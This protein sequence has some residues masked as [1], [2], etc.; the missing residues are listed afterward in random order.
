M[1][2]PDHRCCKIDQPLRNQG[3]MSSPDK[4]R[5]A[6]QVQLEV[7]EPHGIGPMASGRLNCHCQ[8]QDGVGH[9][10]Y[11]NR[12]T[13][14]RAPSQNMATSPSAEAGSDP[15]TSPIIL[16]DELDHSLHSGSSFTHGFRGRSRLSEAFD[17]VGFPSHQA[18]LPSMSRINPD[19]NPLNRFCADD[20]APWN[21]THVSLTSGHP[22]MSSTYGFGRPENTPYSYRGSPRSAEE[23][24][25]IGSQRMDSGYHTD[26]RSDPTHSLAPT[27]PSDPSVHDD[28]QSYYHGSQPYSTPVIYPQEHPYGQPPSDISPDVRSEYPTRC[29]YQGCNKEMKNHSESK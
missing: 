24:S 10:P 14:A 8:S 23:Y 3:T 4:R 28:I 27:C 13:A 18:P 11:P 21:P 9:T 22:G 19:P 7:R 17:A 12:Y 16:S 25:G 20:A 29:D 1:S 6:R 5:E 15:W 2:I 26:T